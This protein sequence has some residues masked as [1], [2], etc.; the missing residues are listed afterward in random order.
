MTTP[1]CFKEYFMLVEIKLRGKYRVPGQAIKVELFEVGTLVEYFDLEYGQWL[2]DGGYA[3]LPQ[4][5]DGLKVV[6]VPDEKPELPVI[7]AGQNL[8]QAGKIGKSKGRRK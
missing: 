5:S 6:T 3:S 1:F 2:I 7:P 8:G 4:D